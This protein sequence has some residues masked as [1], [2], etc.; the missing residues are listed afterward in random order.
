MSEVFMR[1]RRWMATT[2][3]C[4]ADF[5]FSDLNPFTTPSYRLPLQ[6]IA[7]QVLDQKGEWQRSNRAHEVKLCMDWVVWWEQRLSGGCDRTSW[8]WTEIAILRRV[9]KVRLRG[10]WGGARNVKW[11]KRVANLFEPKVGKNQ[12]WDN[13]DFEEGACNQGRRGLLKW[14]SQADTVETVHLLYLHAFAGNS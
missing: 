13:G 8:W 11:G 4:S 12:G 3:P 9:K 2:A 6:R 5:R 7:D 14:Q 10:M 1:E